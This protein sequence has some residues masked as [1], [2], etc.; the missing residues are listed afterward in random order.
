[1]A[2]LALATPVLAQER[3]VHH[4]I[5]RNTNAIVRVFKTKSGGRVEVEAAS[6]KVTKAI[7]G[8]T[9]V[10]TMREGRDELVMTMSEKALTVSSPSGRVSAPRTDR[11]RLER[12]RVLIAESIVGR[13][14]A[15]LIG[16]LGLGPGSPVQPVLFSTRVFVLAAAGESIGRSEMLDSFNK[17]RP[18]VRPVLLKA[19]WT[20]QKGMTPTECWD[21]YVKEAIA[22]YMEYEE[23]MEDVDWWEILDAAAC[24]A[25]YDMR[26]IGAMSWWLSCVSLN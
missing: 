18:V 7:A 11:T 22:A 2:G 25:I 8:T 21:A 3:L 10:T 20:G 15:A 14:A 1:M 5:D 12:A 24:A 4:E 6:L 9:V 16:R 23:C 13:R 26:A 19:S 17:A